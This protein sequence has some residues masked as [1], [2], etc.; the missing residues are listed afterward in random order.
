MS[1]TLTTSQSLQGYTGV[2]NTPNAQVLQTG[3]FAF[4][5]NNQFDNHLRGYDYS[6]LEN[7]E[8]NYILGIGLFSFL[9][10]DGRVADAPG[11]LMDL[12]ANIKF[13]IPWTPSYL[14]H[15]A[16]GIQDFGGAANNYDNYYG[17]IDKTYGWC[18]FALGYGYAR[19]THEDR[20]RMDGVFASLEIQPRDWVSVMVENDTK[21]NHVALRVATP[22][23]LHLPC[24][25]EAKVVQ[26]I[27]QSATSVSF[28]MNI[29]FLNHKE[30]SVAIKKD[31]SSEVPLQS[32]SQ[33][34]IVVSE[35]HKVYKKL[36][37]LVV[38]QPTIQALEK[39]MMRI[40]FEN[41]RIVKVNET[42]YV[43]FENAVFDAND[44][45]AFGYVLGMLAMSGVSY[46]NYSVTLLKNN[47]QTLTLL[48]KKK[49]LQAFFLEDTPYNESV[50]KHNLVCKR[51]I[52]RKRIPYGAKKR[53]SFFIPRVEFSLGM[54]STIATEYGL[55]DYIAALRT[56]VSMNLYDGLVLSAMYETPFAN[57][58]DF[59]EGEVY[60]NETK[61]S[62]RLVTAMIHQTIHIKDVFSTTS[63]GKYQT[64]YM[65]I[66]NQ[67]TY[68]PVSGEHALAFRGG[69]FYDKDDN[70]QD[71]YLFSY[72][73]NYAPK[74]LFFELEYG[75]FWYGDI[76]AQ[77][78]LKRFFRDLSVTLYYKNSA[79]TNNGSTIEEEFAGIEFAFPF[80]LRKL[81][82]SQHLHIKGK[83]DWHYSIF[84][85]IN[86]D[87]GTNT[88]NTNFGIV[89]LNDLE[90]ESEYL[91]RDRLNGSYV[92]S[93]LERLR[94]AYWE[95]INE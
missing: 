4:Q 13:K 15:F 93:H 75:K 81:P 50:F 74:D 62:N 18:R 45:D 95:Y 91:N 57:S 35:H 54:T 10:I 23:S 32:S 64:D 28:V 51:T 60:Y 58:H 78:S 48:G 82:A 43:E 38:I 67:T 41:I 17:V 29:P 72:R 86:K 55:F 94:N 66:L 21:E 53:S 31:S 12:S 59:D 63:F 76:G 2:I 52:N 90:L 40:G 6:R 68:A 87:D 88:L 37:S 3:E 73:Y 79:L 9:E 11:Y 42:L 49:P 20:K 69:W 1:S 5:Y 14:P 84:S 27:T 34:D 39:E 92:K 71:F 25:F 89:P 24:K 26:N 44:L 47:L 83:R 80:T 7:G 46:E 8:K 70:S 19:N 22:S 16:F 33:E 77:L 56:N 30:Y 36:S 61:M 85:T 65:G